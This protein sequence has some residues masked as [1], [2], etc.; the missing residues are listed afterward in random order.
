MGKYLVIGKNG[1]IA[2][3]FLGCG[4]KNIRCTSSTANSSDDFFLDLRCPD[5]FEYETLDK[6]TMVVFLAAVSSP[7]ACLN[8]FEDSYSINVTGTKYFIDRALAKNA[9]VLFFSS[10]TVY[11][12]AEKEVTEQSEANPLGQYAKMKAEVEN[13]FKSHENF[14]VFRLSY[15]LSKEDKFLKYLISCIASGENVEIFEPFDRSVIYLKDVIDA[16][17]SVYKKWDKFPETFVN[18]AGDLLLSRKNL[19]D[20]INELSPSAL[21]YSVVTPHEDFYKARPQIINMKS[22]CL[23]ELLGRKTT[24][25]KKAIE[26]ELSGVIL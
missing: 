25:I 17:I 23:H 8:N 24:S 14:K 3:A 7:D 1:Y 20:I 19:A 5:K 13:A 22:L 9:K 15:V 10:D 21:N 26:I 12:S 2:K 6:E 18:L 16:I 11:G 4:E